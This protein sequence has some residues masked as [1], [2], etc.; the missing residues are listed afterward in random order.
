M[1]ATDKSKKE[2]LCSKSISPSV[3]LSGLG[4]TT[5]K[6]S[7]MRHRSRKGSEIRGRSPKRPV[8]AIAKKTSLSL[9]SREHS[10]NNTGKK[11]RKKESRQ[12]LGDKYSGEAQPAPSNDP[13]LIKIVKPRKSHGSKN[14]PLDL[15][16]DVSE[17]S[18][19]GQYNDE[20]VE[21]DLARRPDYITA[22]TKK[23]E[24]GIR[25][26]APSPGQNAQTQISRKGDR[27]CDPCHGARK[28]S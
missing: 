21:R 17:E 5:S 23:A 10:A 9:L 24:V 16:G 2:Q 20:K 8:S 14:K 18:W 13:Q 22:R 25:G 3:D 27:I 15:N 19:H 28:H 12:T 7:S 4:L 6:A 1:S 26:Q 11:G